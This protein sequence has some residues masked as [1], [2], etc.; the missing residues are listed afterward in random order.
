LDEPVA[1]DP[2][3]SRR[4]P[5]WGLVA[6]VLGLV[7]VLIALL[8]V[9]GTWAGQ[10]WVDQGVQDLVVQVDDAASD[11]MTQIRE[12][13]TELEQQALLATSDADTRAAFAAGA[14]LARGVEAQLLTV[15]E[16]AGNVADT[17][18]GVVTVT[19]LLVTAML[20]YQILVHLGIF[21][22]GRHWRRD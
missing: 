5:G 21:T 10:G 6:Q 1:T 18:L 16:E 7:G 13:T 19:A 9:V 11:A 15:Q 8:L 4:H 22:L 20:V 12:V 3:T 2:G 17:L 14:E